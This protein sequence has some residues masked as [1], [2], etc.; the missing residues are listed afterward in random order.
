MNPPDAPPFPHGSLLARRRELAARP[1]LDGLALGRE[2]AD[3]ADEWLRERFAAALNGAGANGLALLAVGGLGRRELLPGSDLDLV[4][5]H[6]K[7][8]DARGVAERLWYPIWDDL[9]NLDHSVRTPKEV[10]AAADG[11]LKVALGL[12][13]A[14]L[15]VGDEKL[16]ADVGSRVTRLWQARRERWLRALMA[17]IAARHQEFGD[18]AF[19]LEPDLK[20]GRGGLRDV[21][22]LRAAAR[23]TSVLDTTVGDPTLAHAAGELATVLSALQS[24][25]GLP[26]ASAHRTR[27]LLQDQDAVAEVL[28]KGDADALMA[29]VAA[30][31]RTVA[32]A[33]DDGWRRVERWIAGPG[34]RTPGSDRPVGPGLVRRDDEI[35][36][37]ADAD[38]A[39][40]PS[41]ALRAA[42][43]S[44][45]G[46]V[47]MARASLQ[48]LADE[49][50]PPP[51]PWP[52]ELRRA[53]VRLL[54]SGPGAIAAI[55]ALDQ[56]GLWVRLI[57][58]WAVVRNRPQR[59]AFHRF[60]V[61]RHLLEAALEASHLVRRVSR[62]D[63]LIIG[64]L[65]HDIGKGHPGD[66]SKVGETLAM[67]IARRMGFSPADV[68]TLGVLARHHLLLPDVATR[69]DID[70]PATTAFVA[71][72]V[73]DVGELELLAALSEADGRATG[74]TAWG[75]WKAELVENLTR[76]AS[77]LLAGES[78]EIESPAP[79]PAEEALLAARTVGVVGDEHRV[80][81]VTPDAPG[82]L[83]I[84][85]GVLA[86]HGVDVRGATVTSMGD[87][88]ARQTFDVAPAFTHLPPWERVRAD[89]EAARDGR[90]ALDTRLAES[91]RAYR[92]ARRARQARPVGPEEV[93]VS[94][95]PEASD[96]AT[97]L[98]VRAPDAAGVLSRIAS[99]LAACG[100]E[101]ISAR[102][103]TM[104]GEVVDA[105]YVQD[106]AGAKIPDDK[107][108]E[109]AKAVAA[110]LSGD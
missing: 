81:V 56:A 97:V 89:I 12:L 15:V 65:L 4:L 108:N 64:A 25:P 99:T 26:A 101:I 93:E 37:L 110:A 74:P 16:A 2:A 48:R 42:I 90:L 91:E 32:W 58:E 107:A 95:H 98:E 86:L 62:P 47:P 72:V 23:V 55:E 54:D 71:G 9:L 49:T 70:D 80:T 29:R 96:T 27:L 77:G 60:T 28:G 3:A 85:T 21:H 75:G 20:E 14:R 46:G 24:V 84:I 43:A 106:L 50:L 104:G 5:V 103:T 87:G 92:R 88:M 73:S 78:F 39:A 51:D 45:E 63:L 36:V 35:V 40:D 53:L 7:R 17:S 83:G 18:V 22:A 67:T 34:G 41:L 57:P 68:H 19:L 76:R 109:A 30:A 13:D 1:G 44:V 31:A 66:H 11:D 52:E 8:K 10:L 102:A 69:W 61:D 38:P 82:M 100:L 94:V 105:F 59:N 79:T 6:D 33:S